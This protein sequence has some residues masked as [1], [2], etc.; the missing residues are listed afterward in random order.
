MGSLR[1]LILGSAAGG[2]YPQWNCR[3]PVSQRFWDGDP[4]VQSRTQSSIAVSVNG[5]NWL[6]INCSPDI[7]QQI[8]TTSALHPKTGLRS[9]PI[10]AIL[11]TNGDIDHIA[12]LLTL[13]EKQAYKLHATLAVLDVLAQNNIFDAVDREFVPRL[14]VA[15]GKSFEPIEGLS[16]ETFAVPG[17][18]PLYMEDGTPDIG[19]ETETTIGVEIISADGKRALYIPGCAHISDTVRTRI[20]D[21]DLLMFDGTL[22]NDTEMVDAGLGQKT[23]HRMGHISMSGSD[24]SI[25]LLDGLPIKR[26]VFVHINNT[27]P[28]LID[29]SPQRREA[30]ACGWEISYDGMEISL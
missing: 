30:E 6:L 25:A 11:L 22:W 15:L 19:A 20:T 1:I 13:R 8:L 27:N 12:G 24:G 3:G 2:G 10:S 18:V 16:V 17:K 4:N 23:G 28:V 7:R 9:T 26:R 5:E 29:D 21:A 14:P